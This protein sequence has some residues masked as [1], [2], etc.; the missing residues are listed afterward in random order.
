[1]EAAEGDK[2]DDTFSDDTSPAVGRSHAD[3]R[4]RN[5]DLVFDQEEI[6][7]FNSLAANSN[8]ELDFYTEDGSVRCGRG[9]C[10]PTVI[11]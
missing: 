4:T 10:F 3:T 9:D 6:D 8:K 7:F 5:G 2:F 1:M 11:H